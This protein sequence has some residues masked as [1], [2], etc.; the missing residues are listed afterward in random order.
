[1]AELE[2][3]I[4]KKLIEQLV[5]G[6][7]QWTY[8]SDLR[9]EKDLWENFRYI[10]E[11]NNKEKLDD[12]PLSDSE[13]EQ[14]KNQMQFSSFYEAGRWLVGENG[15]VYVHVQRGN[16]TLHL[17]V[18]NQEHISGGT[19]VY[20]VVNQYQALT[21]EEDTFLKE[22]DRRF[23]VSLLINGIPLIHIELK[24]REHSYMDGF[25]QIKKYISEGKFHG[26]FSAVQMFVVSNAVNT[27]YFS[28]ANATELNPK[29]ISGWL[30]KNNKPVADYLDFAKQ[31]LSIPTAHEMV[32][33]YTVLDKEARKLLLLR[34]Y[35]IHAIEAI[36]NASRQGVSGY[37]WHTTGSGKTMTSYKVTRNL[38]MDI[39]A[40]EKTI[41]LIDRKDLDTQT[42]MS[43]QSYAYNDL[44][45]VDDTDN[46]TD[47]I[48]KL[49]DKNRQ[50]IVTTIQKLQIMINRRL[51]EG[52][53]VYE[54]I[55]NLKVAFVV[56]ECHRAVTPATKRT[57]ERFFVNSLWYG[58]TGTPR[59]DVNPYPE[60]GDLPRTTEQLYGKVLHSYTIKEAIHDGAVLGFQV[61]YLGAKGIGDKEDLSVYE[62]ESHMLQVIDTMINRSANKLE[63][64]KGKGQTYEG[65]LTVKS[66]AIAQKYYEL[67]KRVK[68]GESS[69]K[70]NED[71]LKAL[72]DFPKVAITYSVQ[73]NAE[74]GLLNQQKMQEAL[75]DYC[76][77]FG[78]SYDMS[79][80]QSYNRNLNERLARKE[81]KYKRREQ[82]LDFVIVVDRLLTG[83]DAPCLSTIFIDRQPMGPHDL[84]QA[85]SRTN[86][87]YDRLKMYG[88]IVTFQAPKDFKTAVDNAVR[89]YS[90]GGTGDALAG[91]WETTEREFITALATLRTLAAS[92]E[93]VTDLSL[94]QK[95]L[96]I[97][98]FQKFDRLFA[99][100]KSFVKFEEKGLKDYDITN[101][102]YEKYAAHYKNVVEELK[103]DPIEENE[104]KTEPIDEEYE[105]MAYSQV[106]IDYEYI[107]NLIQDIVSEENET[108]TEE[109]RQK[110]L[111][112]IREYI[113]ELSKDNAKLGGLM[114]QILD[115]LEK[116]KDAYRGKN[117]SAIL[118]DMRREA[119]DIVIDNFVKKW[120]VNRDAVCYAVLHSANGEIKDR[121]IL[122]EKAD[123]KKYKEEVEEPLQKFK[124]HNAM[125]AELE[126]VM[127]AEIL[128]L[129]D[130]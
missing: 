47:L 30:D 33:K 84:I 71:I 58:F 14:V 15:M 60:M 116:D 52:T 27:K 75:S 59:F 74:S 107:I 98:R 89:L 42:K 76:R 53:K 93:D 22:R 10:L 68:R 117:I 1:M 49:S 85:F 56:D 77:M 80:I 6:E 126:E 115:D 36:R 21:E 28:A 41:F 96:F 20:E 31:V 72:P 13:F 39:P 70:I 124:Y 48:R 5:S 118:E 113:E 94:K 125:R 32:S 43:F 65:I 18:L 128:P 7:S 83:F 79:Q 29:F 55:K 51:Q 82:Q 66:I 54:R 35:Q 103:S 37:I 40:L 106:R 9:T 91:D 12:I 130:R 24:N 109:E 127:K 110:R 57:L 88:Q 122:K 34:P 25:N 112:E 26:I 69:V 63:L 97:A 2:A 38:L 16:R 92:P 44:I 11:Q 67:F 17:L 101:E 102:E 114:M 100:L 62:Q 99:Q 119:I 105:L 4:E 120:Y 46:V 108:D 73:E 123:Y 81:E 8:R 121:T 87:I 86:R 129:M 50:M 19:S 3:S 23:D 64:K 61:E 78:T 45:D 90:A 104:E 95:K 111:A